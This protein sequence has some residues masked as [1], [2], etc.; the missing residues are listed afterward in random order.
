[1]KPP[2]STANPSPGTAL[3]ADRQAASKFRSLS[4]ADET[5]SLGVCSTMFASAA[6]FANDNSETIVS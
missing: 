4:L 5:N 2:S 1:M 3:Y 6:F